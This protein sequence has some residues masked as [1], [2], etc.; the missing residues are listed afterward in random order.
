MKTVEQVIEK[1]RVDA[2]ERVKVVLKHAHKHPVLENIKTMLS[3]Y[4]CTPNQDWRTY[5]HATVP[6]M[7]SYNFHDMLDDIERLLPPGYEL[8]ETESKNYG[9]TH[10]Y[11][12]KHPDTLDYYN[13]DFDPD[14]CKFVETGNLIPELKKVCSWDM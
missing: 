13:I 2:E 10:Y 8:D 7:S 1:I 4:G 5:I 3:A 12:W 6:S 9:S 14:K 11:Y